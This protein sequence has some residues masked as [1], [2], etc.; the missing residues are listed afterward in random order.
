LLKYLRD[1]TA[2]IRLEG[3]EDIDTYVLEENKRI[4]HI[5]V[6]YSESRQEKQ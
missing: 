2:L 6:K 4:Q 5:Q 3:L 1:E